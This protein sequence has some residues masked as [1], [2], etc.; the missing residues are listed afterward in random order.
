MTEFD[1]KYVIKSLHNV[2]GLIT[3]SSVE[4]SRPLYQ[5]ESGSFIYLDKRGL[6]RFALGYGV[7]RRCFGKWW[8][9]ATMTESERETLHSVFHLL[10]K[11]TK[12]AG[13]DRGV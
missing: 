1:P 8:K 9:T 7:G 13:V 10:L 5:L 6:F 3:P 2:W 4:P 11:E 12:A